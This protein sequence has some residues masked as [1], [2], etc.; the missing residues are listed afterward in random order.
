MSFIK[1]N[2][3]RLDTQLILIVTITTLFLWVS[4]G[5][6]SLFNH[7]KNLNENLDQILRET[8]E[9]ILPIALDNIFIS[10]PEFLIFGKKIN[11]SKDSE[12]NEDY[13]VYQI[14]RWDG[15]ILLQS[16][17]SPNELLTQKIT[18]GFADNEKYRIFTKITNDKRFI[19]QVAE[20]K[21]HRNESLL[22]SL[23]IF[24]AP[25]I[26]FLPILSVLIIFVIKR[27]WRA[28]NQLTESIESVNVRNLKP[29][30]VKNIYK[31]FF[32][33]VE[34]TNSL[35]AKVNDTINAEKNFASN[36]A[37]EIRTPLTA[38]L[39][40]L[41]VLKT[42]LKEPLAEEVDSIIAS[43]FKLNKLIEKILELSRAESGIGLKSTKVNME[44][45]LNSVLQD[46]QKE[47]SRILIHN[48][49]KDIF[50]N[51]DVD[52]VG[53]VLRNLIENALKYSPINKSIRVILDKENL[54]IENYNDQITDEEILGIQERHKSSNHKYFSG[55]IG[56]SI[57]MLLS[58]Q[59]NLKVNFSI[60]NKIFIAE[61]DFK[62]SLYK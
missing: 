22:E 16:S 1:I 62:N 46:F 34:V 58:K 48:K 28:V 21:H 3:K 41:Q 6:I 17:N 24:L 27:S 60:L 26:L 50:I 44:V 42:K 52:A 45:V 5:S 12:E 23:I 37:H 2:S 32:P 11:K 38:A 43:L 51:G 55:G 30:E 19:I 56:L 59:M 49:I 13:I 31:D 33:I 25:L 14:L 53:I 47:K 9:R 54:C 39:S 35:I 29:I 15:K 57:V 18:P 40:Q 8:A 7:Y 4:A 36:S 20:D 61:V 10:N